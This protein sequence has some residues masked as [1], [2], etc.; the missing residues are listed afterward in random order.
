MT[1]AIQYAGEHLWPGRIGHAAIILAFTAGLFSMF[2]YYFATRREAESAEAQQW[3]RM[4]R[5]GFL[6]HGIG[7][8]SVILML[9]YVMLNKY[10]EYQYVQAHV[11]DDLVFRYVFSA[12]WEG[13]EGSFLLWMFW[14][15]VL[16]MLLI[17]SSRQ[18]E[19]YVLVVLG[20][21]QVI[22][23][24]MILGVYVGF[25]DDPMR[26]GSNPTLLLRDVM[27]APIFAN[28]NYVELLEGTGLN[29]LLQNWWMTV[30][31]PTLF[32]GF[33][34][35][36][37]PFA[38]AIAGLWTRRHREWLQPALPWALMSGA[39]L[40][41]GI[42]MGGAWAYEALSFGGYWAWDPVE[43]MSLV[44][45]LI[46][47][48]GIHTNL[49]ARSTDHSIRATYAY[50]LLTFLLIVYSTFLTR[51]GVLGETSV[52][53]FTEMGLETQLIL[54][55]ALY[56]VWSAVLFFSR[57]KGVPA[58]EKEEATS[59]KEFWMFMGS[60]VLLFSSILITGATSLPVYNKIRAFFD[61]AY[62]GQ[63]I[64]DPV[65]HYNKYQLWIGVFIGLL[66]GFSQYLRFREMNFAGRVKTVGLRI[67][68]AAVLS[69]A[70]SFLTTYWINAHAWQYQLLLFSGWFALVT[71]IDY[72]ISYIK[73]D[74]K[75]AGSVMAHVGFGAMLL[76]ILASGLNKQIISQNPFLMEGLTADE[77]SKRNTVI[78]I[79]DAPMI[80]GPYEVTLANDTIN[81]LTRTYTINYKRRNEAGELSEEFELNP[82][83]LYD[84]SFT[85]IAASNPSTKQYWDRDI[86]THVAALPVEEMDI[87][88]KKSKEDSLNYRSFTL[89]IGQAMSFLDTVKVKSSDSFLV[90]RY[91]VEAVA[92][93]RN[94]VHPEYQPETGD[95]AIGVKF[96]L[97][98]S[99]DDAVYEAEPVLVLRDELMY[100]YPV[101]L[102]A[103]NTRI[104]LDE[105]I[106]DEF[107]V[108]E[109]MLNYREIRLK[110]G[111]KITFEGLEIDFVGFDKD[112]DHPYY[113]PEKGD[114]AVGAV[115]EVKTPDADTAQRIQPVFFIRNSR[116]LNIKDELTALGLHVR[117]ASLDPNTGQ[118]SLFMARY[119]RTAEPRAQFA[120]A[121]DAYRSDWI[122]LQAIEFPG[123]N[124]FWVGSSLMMLG[125]TLSMYYR[126]RN[127]R[128]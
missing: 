30:H 100:S 5:L 14:H 10:Y 13:Q 6:A 72:L 45:W 7:V 101:Q 119:Q 124:L 49:V 127:Q 96:R 87:N 32:L 67:G 21:I 41:T 28:A 80:L 102:N 20:S 81:G 92:V 121:T 9:F 60:L 50:Y 19:P 69:A 88:A 63:V 48:A 125:L 99:E 128:A 53:A 62:V 93:S 79:K 109:D 84:K 115:L 54:F 25:G 86:F 57:Y 97:R 36:S 77:E 76:G 61:P 12:F 74:L 38:Y 11:N 118:A 126:I 4:G 23:A 35:T 114:I 120:V 73:T 111:E 51:S 113:R 82:N 78:L 37:I 105:R 1:E 89:G 46:L 56:S 98:S 85:K 44:P 34:S 122:A 65:P 43:N 22:L 29:P 104:K 91:E 94:P 66:S 112:P 108:S 106:F 55:I 33:A 18:W 83:V 2:S 8:V 90:K 3:L 16:G 70:L 40:G 103:I 123:I 31:P 39:I 64:T 68:A 58:P 47:V 27:D 17:F 24:S 26:I 42:L 110:Q 59:S 117:F 71:N 107:F 75:V 52:H 95:I 116:P 15:V